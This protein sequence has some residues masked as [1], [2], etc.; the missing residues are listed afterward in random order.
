MGIIRD[1]HACC[2]NVPLM[3]TWFVI[4]CLA[5]TFKIYDTNVHTSFKVA[6]FCLL[7][8]TKIMS[9]CELHVSIIIM[10]VK[11]INK[12]HNYLAC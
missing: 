12:S 6:Y 9:T 8:A 7:H 1:L 4:Q 11:I 3:K 2:L 5:L 10:H